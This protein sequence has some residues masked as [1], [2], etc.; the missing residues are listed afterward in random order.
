MN[1]VVTHGEDAVFE[2]ELSPQDLQAITQARTTRAA[3]TATAKIAGRRPRNLPR[4]VA[5]LGAVSVIA[6][7]TL[8]I[9]QRTPR[10]EQPGSA[11][12]VVAPAALAA[13]TPV[14]DVELAAPPV[15]FANPF[16][17]K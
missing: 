2:V 11:V 15:K 16:D 12:R 8:F 9:A 10:I 14:P 6:V 3:D 17:R 13:A 1:H 4:L 5:G 7:T